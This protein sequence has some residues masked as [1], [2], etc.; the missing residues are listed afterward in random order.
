MDQRSAWLPGPGGCVGLTRTA[1]V[2]ETQIRLIQESWEKLVPD[3]ER[4]ALLFYTRLFE[5][6]PG[7]RPLFKGDMT[8]QGRQ[9]LTMIGTAISQLKQLDEVSSALHALGK[10]HSAYGVKPEHYETFASALMWTLHTVLGADFYPE[11]EDAWTALYDYLSDAMQQG[12]TDE[13]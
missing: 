4:A 1:N 3:A 2:E 7:L 12:A 9:L 8:K 11:V 13:A 5:L 6:D 10:R